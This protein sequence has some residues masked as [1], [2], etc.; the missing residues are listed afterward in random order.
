M[1]LRGSFA[2]AFTLLVS[3]TVNAYDF[4][5]LTEFPGWFQ[6]A[7]HREIDLEKTSTLNIEDLGVK[8]KV[9]GKW[10]LAAKGAD[11]WYY[12]VD[13]GST[14]P[15]ECYVFT[16]FDGVATSLNSIVEHSIM[17]TAE[18]V[19]KDISAK[20]NYAIGSGTIGNTP[21]IAFDTLYS[22]G[23]GNEKVSALLKS[24]SAQNSQS[25]QICVHNELGYRKTFEAVYASFIEAFNASETRQDFFQ[26][27][28]QMVLN[29]MPIGYSVERYAQDEEGDIF[30]QK[31][32]AFII[33]VGQGA[34]ATSDSISNGWSN[35]NGALIN[36]N[37]LSIEN[38]ELANQLAV[39]YQTDHWQVEGVQK[40]EEINAAL[41][42]DS[43]LLSNY[44][45]YVET[46]A[47]QATDY[48]IGEYSAWLPE[49]SATEATKV[50]ITETRD[51][52]DANFQIEM[53]PLQMN[54]LTDDKGIIQQGS[55]QHGPVTMQLNLVYVEGQPLLQPV[56]QPE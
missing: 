47:L 2:I 49:A 8:Q 29:D 5:D 9:L 44:G 37:V 34:V 6:D 23:E 28:Y 36:A 51:D 40:G 42:H 27:V 53:G 11:H 1:K 41:A 10:R 50:V 48:D 7:M 25:L 14:T 19:G 32:A 18:D 38:G 4:V 13:I 31:D 54:F 46:S 21:Y 3:M 43:W 24:A 20:V 30:G 22:L 15:V 35:I 55:I 52:P 16:S 33:P 12:M 45:A 17:A 26:V 56:E 39:S